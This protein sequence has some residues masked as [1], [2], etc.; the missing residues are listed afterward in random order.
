M[1]ERTFDRVPSKPDPRRMASFDLAA[2]VDTVQPR[3]YTWAVPFTLDQGREGAC[4]AHAVTHEAV[5]RPVT[6]DFTQ[7]PLPDWAGRARSAFMGAAASDAVAQAFA[8]DAYDWCRRNDEW[9]GEAYDGTSVAAG[10]KAMVAAGAWG[11]Y[12]W[13]RDAHTLAVG[14]SRRGPAVIGVDWWTGFFSPDS[15]GYLRMTGQVEGGHAVLV[16]GFSVTKQAFKIHQSWGSDWGN[17]GEAWMP[18]GVMAQLLHDGGEAVLPQ[19][20]LL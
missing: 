19:T 4:V 9:A 8:F 5:A 7:H 15:G 11:E 13:T 10:A 20:R 6:V 18:K 3:S 1:T 12:R 16:N 14:V 2:V 17:N